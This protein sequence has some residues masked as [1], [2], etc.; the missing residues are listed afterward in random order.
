LPSWAGEL[1]AVGTWR[2]RLHFVQQAFF[3]RHFREPIALQTTAMDHLATVL[4]ADANIIEVLTTV[5][6]KN[7]P[8]VIGLVTTGLRKPRG[9]ISQAPCA[10]FAGNTPNMPISR[11]SR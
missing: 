6:K 7:Q 3:I 2:A 9:R 4:G 11:S 5:A 10:Y 8:D 1:Y